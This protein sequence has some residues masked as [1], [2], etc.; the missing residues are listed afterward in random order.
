MLCQVN[1]VSICHSHAKLM[2]FLLRLHSYIYAKKNMFWILRTSIFILVFEYVEFN[3]HSCTF[4][5]F[6]KYFFQP[7]RGL[8]K[9]VLSRNIP[10]PVSLISDKILFTFL[11]HILRQLAFFCPN[12]LM[13]SM[14]VLIVVVNRFSDASNLFHI[15]H[16]IPTSMDI[17]VNS[18]C[19]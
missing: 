6:C 14:F 1:S 3:I 8:I 7:R 11:A 2:Y 10:W 4:M 19:F 12:A 16:R 9:E 13:T 5:I 17:L 18:D 15:S